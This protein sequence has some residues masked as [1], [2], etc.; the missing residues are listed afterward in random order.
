MIPAPAVASA[1]D[2]PADL[3]QLRIRPV[4]LDLVGN[5]VQ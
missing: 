5:E 4:E 2:Q 1:H 3:H